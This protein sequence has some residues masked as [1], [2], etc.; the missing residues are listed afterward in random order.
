MSRG[1]RI[2]GP[3]PLEA[4]IADP[5]KYT[6]KR[7]AWAYG[8]AAKGSE[9]EAALLAVLI[10]KTRIARLQGPPASRRRSSHGNTWARGRRR[11]LSAPTIKFARLSRVLASTAATFTRRHSSAVLGPDR[12]A[13]PARG[14]DG[15]VRIPQA[16]G[17]AHRL[18][19]ALI[20]LPPRRQVREPH[21][22]DLRAGAP[23]ST[24]TSNRAMHCVRIR[25]FFERSQAAS[26]RRKMDRSRRSAQDI[27]PR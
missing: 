13:H 24:R 23:M 18:P 21:V 25:T 15:G 9:I 8:C 20:P 1:E 26:G 17:T 27:A 16:C 14:P 5:D 22:R 19:R 4:I 11:H 7:A 3:G 10:E 12:Q 2:K 6:L